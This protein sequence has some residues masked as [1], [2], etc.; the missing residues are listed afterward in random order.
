MD[1]NHQLRVGEPSAD[2]DLHVPGT[3]D[4]LGATG[5]GLDR[6]ETFLNPLASDLIGLVR[7]NGWGGTR[8]ASAYIVYCGPGT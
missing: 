8:G 6:I 1:V 2:A 5:T 4:L 7:M 3:D